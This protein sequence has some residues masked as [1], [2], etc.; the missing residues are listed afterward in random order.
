MSPVNEEIRESEGERLG[1]KIAEAAM[2][3]YVS[4]EENTPHAAGCCSTRISFCEHRR[5]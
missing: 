3:I 5:M 4:V 1:G 2:S